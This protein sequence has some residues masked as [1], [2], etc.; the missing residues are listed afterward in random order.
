MT[1]LARFYLL[2]WTVVA[3]M[4][5]HSAAF[6]ESD[7]TKSDPHA[8]KMPPGMMPS[9]G[10]AGMLQQPVLPDSLRFQDGPFDSTLLTATF[11][12]ETR[13]RLYPKF[14]QLDTV[15]FGQNF[16]LG[17]DEEFSAKVT[18]FNPHL[19]ITTKGEYKKL[20]DTL[21][22][23]SVRVQVMQGDSL[24]QETWGFYFV[25]APHFRG[26]NYF[27]FKLVSFMVNDQKYTKAPEPVKE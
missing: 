17:E 24:V 13:H 27:G 21:Y 23:P 10:N 1:K 3:L 9:H 7:S 26:N 18:R 6:G 5:V 20:S 15:L 8:P 12:I 2:V 4:V 25:D 16:P 14:Y 11:V 19:M 22:N